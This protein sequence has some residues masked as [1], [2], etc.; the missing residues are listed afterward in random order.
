MSLP[1]VSEGSEHRVYF[2][3]EK[4]LVFKATKPGLFGESYFIADG[5][6]T[7]KNCSPFDYIVRLRLWKHVFDSA[8]VHLGITPDGQIVSSHEFISGEP[9]TQPE[10]DAFL[11][12]EGFVPVRKKYW[13]W[14][15][16]YP[17]DAFAIGLGDARADNFVKSSAGIVP[18]DV[19]LWISPEERLKTS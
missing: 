13:L 3:E 14:E 11:E 2:D 6:I 19:R 15:K 16:P 8:P 17:L 10:V 12:R 7:Q 4:G 1:R 9:P 5:K 18:I